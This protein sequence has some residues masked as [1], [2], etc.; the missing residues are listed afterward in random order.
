MVRF[1]L[2]L[3]VLLSM[4]VFTTS[5]CDC[6]DEEV[7]PVVETLDATDIMSVSTTLNGNLVAAGESD[8]GYTAVWFEWWAGS[9]EAGHQDTPIQEMTKSGSFSAQIIGT[10]PGTTYSFRAC[11]FAMPHSVNGAV[12][13]FY[14]P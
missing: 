1:L 9:N 2:A 3:I 5:A 4:I 7:H 13:T 14:V 8:E 11:A 10:M 12:R 6:D